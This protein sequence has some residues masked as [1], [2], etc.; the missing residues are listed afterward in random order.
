MMSLDTRLE[1]KDT[2]YGV[3]ARL[4]IRVRVSCRGV[5]GL[6]R[7]VAVGQPLCVPH[8]GSVEGLE[9]PGLVQILEA[10]PARFEVT[11]VRG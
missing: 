3:A 5:G 10:D 1:T 7:G 8:C 9:D 6:C 4:I 2:P 11:L